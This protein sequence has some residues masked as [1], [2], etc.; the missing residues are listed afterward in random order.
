LHPHQKALSW[1]DLPQQTLVFSKPLALEG[2]PQSPAITAPIRCSPNGTPFL[3]MPLPPAFMTRAL[4]S[5]AKSEKVTTYANGN[6]IFGLDDV[7]QLNYFPGDK[8]V[9]YLV[10]A[11]EHDLTSAL[12]GSQSTKS[13]KN[14]YLLTYASDGTLELTQKIDTLNDPQQIAAFPSGAL[15]TIGLDPIQHD[16]QFNVMDS[17]GQN[18]HPVDIDA[19]RLYEADHLRQFY[20]D[21]PGPDPSDSGMSKAVSAMQLISYGDNLLLVQTGTNYAV[22]E[23]GESGL[24]IRSVRLKLPPGAV[25]DGFIQSSEKLWLAKIS[26]TSRDPSARWLIAFDPDTG[27]AVRRISTTGTALDS[28]ACDADGTFLAFKKKFKDKDDAGT[29]NLLTASSQ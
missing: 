7:N 24:I 12:L 1:A 13:P 26:D 21:V 14:F 3:E 15:A 25:I 20:G 29:W 22:T 16:I 11:P 23:I 2:L 9:I 5:I 18:A 10:E 4:L 6:K 27:D 8:H 17:R 19:N 28:V